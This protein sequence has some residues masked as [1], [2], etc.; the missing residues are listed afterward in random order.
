MCR[1]VVN[2]MVPKFSRFC[3]SES[4][5]VGPFPL[6]GLLSIAV[7]VQS[8]CTSIMRGVLPH[9]VS[10]AG[11]SPSYRSLFS[12]RIFRLIFLRTGFLGMSDQLV[13]REQV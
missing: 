10:W 8:L 1:V 3:W 9:P 6:S 5:L 4:T 13:L 7:F 11:S 12:T 2:E